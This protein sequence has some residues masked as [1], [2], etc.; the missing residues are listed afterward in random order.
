M[1]HVC[2]GKPAFTLKLLELVSA[3]PGF[4]MAVRMVSSGN[5]AAL[6][7]ALDDLM[8]V[9]KPAQRAAERVPKLTSLFGLA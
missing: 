5:K 1:C 9:A 2:S 3:F 6:A 7:A 8:G 4:S